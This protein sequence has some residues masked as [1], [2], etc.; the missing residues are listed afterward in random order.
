MSDTDWM[1]HAR[2]AEVGTEMFFP[3]ERSDADSRGPE[4]WSGEGSTAMLRAAKDICRGC[5]V[6]L[7]CLEFAV[8]NGISY[9]LW[10]GLT[11]RNLAVLVAERTTSQGL[12]RR[13]T[14]G[15][16]KYLAS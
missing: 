8:S 10:G 5:P 6:R 12:K 15:A 3:A 7:D 9:G 13:E 2:C 1:E 4:H 11:G 16:S 14:N